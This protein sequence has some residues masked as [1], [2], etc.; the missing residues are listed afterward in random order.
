MYIKFW[1][2]LWCGYCLWNSGNIVVLLDLD[3]PRNGRNFGDFKAFCLPFSSANTVLTHTCSTHSFVR[4][5][6]TRRNRK[7]RYFTVFTSFLSHDAL[8]KRGLRRGKMSVCPSVFHTPV[9]CRNSWT[10]SQTFSPSDN[11]S[12]VF[13]YQTLWQKATWTPLWGRRIHRCDKIVIFDICL[14]LSQ[15]WCKIGP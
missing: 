11:S 13:P 1:S 7:K 10:E 6:V 14:F 8:H 5:R 15:K 12:L 2:K 4:K 9:L 3:C